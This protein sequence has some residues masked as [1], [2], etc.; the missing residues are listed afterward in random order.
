MGPSD[1]SPIRVHICD[2]VRWGRFNDPSAIVPRDKPGS[3]DAG[4]TLALANPLP[5]VD[6]VWADST[7][8][9][10]ERRATI[11]PNRVAIGREGWRVDGLGSRD[12]GSDSGTPVRIPRQTPGDRQRV[13]VNAPKSGLRVDVSATAG[14][15]SPYLDHDGSELIHGNHVRHAVKW[16]RRDRTDAR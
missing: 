2:R 10:P 15:V 16:S 5:I 6:E 14:A 8:V 4:C 11:P 1:P 12:A 7:A 3:V 13:N 9:N